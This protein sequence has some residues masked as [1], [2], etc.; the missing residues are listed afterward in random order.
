MKNRPIIGLI[1]ILALPALSFCGFYVAQAGADLF[2][3]SSEVILVRNGNRTVVTMANDFQGDVKDFAMVVP[4]PEVLAREDIRVIERDI[5][6][7]FDGYSGPRLVEYWDDDPCQDYLLKEEMMQ[8]AEAVE[9]GGA[10]F[11]GVTIE[12]E[13]QVGEY[14]ILI[15]SATE[16]Q[17]LKNWL[18]RNGYQIPEKANEVL[19][20]YIKSDL[21]FFVV[22]VNLEELNQTGYDYLRPLQIEY[23][24]EE[25][26]LPIRL[27]M[28]NADGN[29]DLI[30]YALSEKGMIEC[31]NYQTYE[32]PSNLDIPVFVKDTFDAF[33]VDL[34]A[35]THEL[36]PKAVF[37][38]YSWNLDSDNY[39][40]CDPCS[41]EPPYFEDLELAGVNWLEQTEQEGMRGNNYDGKLHFT[42]LHVRY[43]RQNFPQDLL[44]QETPNKDNFQARYIMNH[45]YQGEIDC[46]KGISYQKDLAKRKERELEN[47]AQLTGW[48]GADFPEFVMRNQQLKLQAEIS[49]RKLWIRYG[50]IALVLILIMIGG[51]G[52]LAL[53]KD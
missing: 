2:N 29:Q 35:K 18:T 39:L 37:L 32:V 26:M 8:S 46:I 5:F 40:K 6:V 22:K 13:Y 14:Q 24:S 33:Y 38:E 45:P 15:L 28:A 47:L 51:I 9:D 52:W 10:D 48:N 3:H 34:F 50:G 12:A 43:N 49:Q 41:G 20:P 44:F 17:G 31:T 1:I 36:N 4:V 19:E 25:F 21:K 16:S 7:R 23:E 27:G 53:R 11:E 42:R 30:I